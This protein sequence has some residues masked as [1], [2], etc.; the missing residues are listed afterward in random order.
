MATRAVGAV[1]GSL[2]VMPRGFDKKLPVLCFVLALGHSGGGC[3]FSFAAGL[4]FSSRFGFFCSMVQLNVLVLALPFLV[5][6][7]AH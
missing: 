1:A 3:L 6:L 4:D 2:N 7:V 5:L